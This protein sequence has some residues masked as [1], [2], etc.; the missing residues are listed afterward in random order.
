MGHIKEPA[1]IDLIVNPMPLSA[2]DR[3]AISAIIAN[4]KRTGEVPKSV[5]RQEALAKKKKAGL[6][7]KSTKANSAGAE[8]VTAA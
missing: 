3:E 5:E 8:K 1:G 7:R 6:K 4:Y 2:E